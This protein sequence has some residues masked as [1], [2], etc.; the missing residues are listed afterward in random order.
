M[1]ERD[2][3]PGLSGGGAVFG[4]WRGA[5]I[6]TGGGA[7]PAVAE[8]A[9]DLTLAEGVVRRGALA[10]SLVGEIRL[11]GCSSACLELRVCRDIGLQCGTPAGGAIVY[12]VV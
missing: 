9:G 2:V 1:S 12:L 10:V 7:F 5:L 6:V 11:P 4:C 3:A 8:K